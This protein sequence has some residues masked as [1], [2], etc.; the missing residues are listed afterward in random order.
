MGTNAAR[1]HSAKTPGHV[2]GLRVTEPASQSVCAQPTGVIGCD[3]PSMRQSPAFGACGRR[4]AVY[5]AF[6]P[7]L[8][9][10]AL[11]IGAIE[12]AFTL[13]AIGDVVRFA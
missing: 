6:E 9:F 13:T 3:A 4:T 8:E 11:S 1:R 2:R 5:G 7:S 12:F 10:V